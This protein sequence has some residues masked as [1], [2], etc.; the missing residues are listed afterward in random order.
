MRPQGFSSMRKT[1]MVNIARRA[2]S[3]LLLALTTVGCG[4]S[5]AVRAA[6]AG[7][8][9]ALKR[10]LAAES[11]RGALDA[12]MAR[13][14]AHALLVQEIR[15][16][17]GSDGM[18]R[19]R[20]LSACAPALEDA[21]EERVNRGDEVAAAAAL[22]RLESQLV[23]PADLV[24]LA[25]SRS[26]GDSPVARAWRA[27]RTRL[28][29]APEDGRERRRRML[30]LDEDVRA[31]ALEAAA[32]ALDRADL[33][34]LLEAA[35]LDPY[36]A[37]RQA[38]ILAAGSLGGGR[39]NRA[40][41]D[42]WT[43]ADDKTRRVIVEAWSMP[44]SFVSGGRH[45]LERVAEANRGIPS[46]IAASILAV[47]GGPGSEQAIGVLVRAIGAGSTEERSFAISSAPLL[48]PQIRDAVV[49]AESDRDEEVAAAALRRRFELPPERGG[50]PKGSSER[51][52]AREKLLEMAK[53]QGVRAMLAK[54]SLSRAGARGVMPLLE[55]D[56]QSAEPQA[57]K[58]AGMSLVALGDLHRAAMLTADADPRVRSS[59]ACAILGKP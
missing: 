47:K 32:V 41:R 5:A 9:A 23:T 14:I 33:D 7:D 25:S 10:D 19:I 21:L 46:L 4:G 26:A 28:L 17:R 34:A 44:P 31:A 50:A 12:D 56:T 51:E 52:A 20:E 58:V 59:I 11:R 37:A 8:I 45:E 43:T 39:V 53:G 13:E 54:L 22:L 38:A 29:I 1:S 15:S 18:T 36:P 35:R 2:A 55:R 3:G 40:L 48:L 57:R 24:E 42:L 30:D 16:S 27:V 6:E 49:A